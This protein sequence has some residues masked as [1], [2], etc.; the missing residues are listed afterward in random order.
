MKKSQKVYTGQIPYT[1]DGSLMEYPEAWRS[2]EWRENTPF[3]AELTFQSFSR[4]RSAANAVYENAA[5]ATFTVF[6]TDFAD[7]VTSGERLDVVRGTWV[8]TKRGQ[9]Y[10]I[11]RLEKE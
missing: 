1:K 4:G 9:N 2:I 8:A 3:E 6:L 5:G 7:L 10:G 11:R